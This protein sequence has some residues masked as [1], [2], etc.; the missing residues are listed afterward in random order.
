METPKKS[1]AKKQSIE[2][3]AKL[4]KERDV[5]AA[6]VEIAGALIIVMSK[7]GKIIY[8]NR[9]CEET[10]GY[11]VAEMK[12]K[13]LWD[14]LVC[15]EDIQPTKAVF[16]ALNAGNSPLKLENHWQA[17]DGSRRLID[18]TL[19]VLTDNTGAILYMIGTGLDITAKRAANDELRR[20]TH[21]LGERVKELN[22]LYGIS[23][24][25]E[26]KELPI[27]EICQGVAE[28]LPPAWQYPEI[29]C[30]RIVLKDYEF[31]TANFK[32]TRWL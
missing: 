2:T 8:F 5:L 3:I 22:C 6:L 15:K 14:F 19:A 21:E 18:W 17:R 12:G 31:T 28:L 29:T 11:S 16:S 25:R 30:A 32:K 9:A 20:R 26:Q 24:L 13:H 7:D 27:E 10:A 4:E 1:R 23:R